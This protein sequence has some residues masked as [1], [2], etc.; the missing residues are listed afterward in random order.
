MDDNQVSN[1]KFYMLRCVVVM[2]HADGIVD[3]AEIAYISAIMN[4]IPLSEEQRATLEDDLDNEKDI[5][6]LLRHINE[7]KYRSQILYFAR[8]MAYKDGNLHPSEAELLEKIHAE[9][10][11]GLDMDAIKHEVSENVR[12]EMTLHDIEIDK[13]RPKRGKHF[14]PWMQVFDE[15]L[16]KLGIDLIRD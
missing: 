1:S 13:Q 4:R 16:L 12:A 8:L 14:V 3:E 6:D 15:I 5:K 9:I 2:A 11:D 10:T 7:P